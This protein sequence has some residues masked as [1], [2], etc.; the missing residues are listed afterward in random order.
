MTI[1]VETNTLIQAPAEQVWEVLSRLDLFKDWCA[2]TSFKQDADIG[3]SL[4]MRVKLYAFPLLVPVKIQHKQMKQGLRWRGGIRG[5]YVGSHY[6][7]VKAVDEKSCAL[8]QGEDFYGFLVP[9]LWPL[10]RKELHRLY[11]SFNDDLKRYCEK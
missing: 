4:L 11:N 9:I 1:Q 5:V 3:D 8:I 10:I 2:R 7:Q 6:F